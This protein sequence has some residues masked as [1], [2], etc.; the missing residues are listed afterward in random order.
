MLTKWHT[1]TYRLADHSCDTADVPEPSTPPAAS[2]PLA[3]PVP[4]VSSRRPDPDVPDEPL[5]DD[6]LDPNAATSGLAGRA[7]KSSQEDK[8][9][10][11]VPQTDDLVPEDVLDAYGDEENHAPE[12]PS[13]HESQAETTAVPASTK[14]T[15][16]SFKRGSE[17]GMP[18]SP[19]TDLP[20]PGRYYTSDDEDHGEPGSA[21]IVRSASTQ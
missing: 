19:S 11:F 14:T 8:L 17:T 21:T 3:A 7:K 15:V 12:H 5:E 16:D 6:I 20:L 13:G 1:E 10:A 9:D 4:V 2:T 18:R